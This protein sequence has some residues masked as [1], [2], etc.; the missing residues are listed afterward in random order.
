VRK[1]GADE[2][3]R[4][5]VAQAKANI[6]AREAGVAKADAPP[7]PATAALVAADEGAVLLG[8]FQETRA[9]DDFA[10][11]QQHLRGSPEG[12]YDRFN[13]FAAAGPLEPDDAIANAKAMQAASLMDE[14]KR[15]RDPETFKAADKLLRSDRKVYDAFSRRS[16]EEWSRSRKLPFPT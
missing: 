16:A 11:W 1:A 2:A 4:A 15:S 8:R 9:P 6:A 14:F 5:L 10:A 12:T 13:R 7:D 3:A